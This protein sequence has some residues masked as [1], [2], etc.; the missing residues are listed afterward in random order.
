MRPRTITRHRQ[1]PN[2]TEALQKATQNPV[3]NLISVPVQNN[4]NFDIG[5]ND[6]TQDVLNIQPVI[7]VRITKGW[8]II[9]RIIQPIVWQPYPS[10][11][12]GGQ[13][14]FGDMSPSFFFSPA[15]PGENNL[16]SGT[17]IR[18]THSDEQLLG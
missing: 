7:P 9:A 11:T 10:Q 5:P 1:P 2:S 4:A 15:K 18:N 8:N 14:G 3:A 13:Y 6:R 12:N 16:G 17:H